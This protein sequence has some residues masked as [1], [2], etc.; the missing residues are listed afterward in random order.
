MF[1]SAPENS[2]QLTHL[3]LPL[4][5]H[6]VANAK[7]GFFSS[8]ASKK[9]KKTQKSYPSV[10]TQLSP[11]LA[12]SPLSWQPAFSH[13]VFCSAAHRAFA[14]SRSHP[15]PHISGQPGCTEP[16]REKK[17]Q[18]IKSLLCNLCCFACCSVALSV[19]PPPH[20]LTPSFWFFFSPWTCIASEL[21]AGSSA[22]LAGRGLATKN[23]LHNQTLHLHHHH[24][25]L[26]CRLQT[27]SVECDSVSFMQQVFHALP[28]Q[29]LLSSCCEGS[30][31]RL[32]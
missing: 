31:T 21:D 15:R 24:H 8:A 7:K 12:S 28:R 25:R 2:K 27:L 6:C 14:L 18:K 19:P 5:P 16:A 17:K 11:Y 30:R 10:I 13:V 3:L 23:Q 26:S 1:D 32:D 20:P 9:K 29:S 22:V 4:S